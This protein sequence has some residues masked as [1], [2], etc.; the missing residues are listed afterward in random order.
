M[1]TWAMVSFIYGLLCLLIA[2]FKP[3]FIYNTKKF[4]IMKKM[5][6]GD[7]GLQ[8]FVIVWGAI[9]VILGLFVIPG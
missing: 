7:M 6:G 5:F 9:F 2:L 4:E 1:G 8:I 3:T